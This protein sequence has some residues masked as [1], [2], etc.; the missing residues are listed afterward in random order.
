MQSLRNRVSLRYLVGAKSPEEETR[1]LG[2]VGAARSCLFEKPGFSEI[3]GFPQKPLRRNPV[4]ALS[5]QSKSSILWPSAT[6]GSDTR[7]LISIVPVL[8][9]KPILTIFTVGSTCEE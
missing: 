8:E 7:M 2:F 3:S 1:F 5:R 4:S 6:E 9:S